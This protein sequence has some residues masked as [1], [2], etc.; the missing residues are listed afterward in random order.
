MPKRVKNMKCGA[1]VAGKIFFGGGRVGVDHTKKKSR[2]G[3]VEKYVFFRGSNIKWNSSYGT[4]CA[5]PFT[6][7]IKIKPMKFIVTNVNK[8]SDTIQMNDHYRI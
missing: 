1:G 4:S 7:I 6:S 2:G 5:F 8:H 3:S